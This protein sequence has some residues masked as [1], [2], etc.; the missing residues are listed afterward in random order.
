MLPTTALHP[1]RQVTPQVEGAARTTPDPV[2]TIVGFS[3]TD[4]ATGEKEA[5]TT[6]RNK[7]EAR[8]I[9]NNE[10]EVDTEVRHYS[11]KTRV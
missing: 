4:R 9:G 3:E 5:G 7:F 8:S 1:Q 10:V 6:G 2:P 11:Q